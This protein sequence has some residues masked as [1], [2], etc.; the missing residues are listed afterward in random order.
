[1]TWDTA[2]EAAQVHHTV[3]PAYRVAI[4]DDE[5]VSDALENHASLAMA[6]QSVVRSAMSILMDRCVAEGRQVAEC[7]IRQDGGNELLSFTV[8]VEIMPIKR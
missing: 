4:V 3:M 7:E 6:Q 5:C 2:G 8:A 1:M